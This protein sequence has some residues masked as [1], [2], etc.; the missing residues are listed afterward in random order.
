LITPDELQP[1]VV[2]AG[3]AEIL[4]IAPNTIQLLADGAT[5]GGVLSAI[6]SRMTSGADGPAPHYHAIAP[7]LFFIISRLH[8]LVGERVVTVSEG[9]FLMVPPGM[10]HAFST[11]GDSGVDMLFL[12][13][14]VDRFEYFRLLDQVRQGKA[15]PRAIL[16]SQERFDNHFLE[17]RVWREFRGGASRT[18]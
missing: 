15:S 16:D 10:P 2:R 9:D 14:K 12:M 11:P 5:T 18:G 6:R 13:P 3:D 8:V 1:V 4:G 7:E 17:S